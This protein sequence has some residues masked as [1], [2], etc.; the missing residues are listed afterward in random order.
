[1]ATTNAFRPPVSSDIALVGDTWV[2]TDGNRKYTCTAVNPDGTTVW[3]SALLT[4]NAPLLPQFLKD[5]DFWAELVLAIDESRDELIDRPIHEL[6]TAR[7]MGVAS[8]YLKIHTA[9]LI[10][11]ELDNLQLTEAEYQRLIEF[12]PYYSTQKGTGAMGR[13]LSFV[14][15]IP[16]T[17][18]Q[19][20]TSDHI[21]FLDSVPEASKLPVFS[22]LGLGSY[23]LSSHYSL[24]V[25]YSTWGQNPSTFN[26][27]NFTPSKLTSLFYLFG[28]CTAVLLVNLVFDYILFNTALGSNASSGPLMMSGT[29][30]TVHSSIA[31][32]TTSAT[33]LMS[34]TY[35]SVSRLI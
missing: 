21:T 3:S 2:Y 18:I 20:W 7:D 11:L 24:A 28:P 34:G 27:A 33:I 25:V 1:M 26:L 13:F 10:G 19:Q 30:G 35:G 14:M 23:Y 17:L 32:T 15:N 16:L 8:R 5:D 29:Y 12:L 9:K 31:C 6:A 4:S 22:P